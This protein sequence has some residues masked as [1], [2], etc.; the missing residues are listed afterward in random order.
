MGRMR[1]KRTRTG[2]Q[3]I[4]TD[5]EEFKGL[6]TEMGG[7]DHVDWELQMQKMKLRDIAGMPAESFD[8]FLDGIERTFSGGKKGQPPAGGAPQGAQPA[9]Q[10]VTQTVTPQKKRGDK[11]KP[12]P[13]SKPTVIGDVD[14]SGNISE[15]EATGLL[16]NTKSKKQ[17]EGMSLAKQHAYIQKLPPKAKANI[18]KLASHYGWPTWRV[19]L[20]EAKRQGLTPAEAEMLAKAYKY[21]PNKR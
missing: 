9:T 20:K 10:P 16:T 21:D 14:G 2:R 7:A 17:L 18:K 13:K 4:K 5:W 11:K 19:A 6:V 3:D 8:D 15:K 12:A 1:D